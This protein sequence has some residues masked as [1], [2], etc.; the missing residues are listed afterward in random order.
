MIPIAAIYARVS[1][2][3]QEQEATIDSQVDALETYA[4][5][6]GYQTS[7]AL[8]FRDQGI[9]GAQLNRPALNRL[10]D[11]A[12]EGHFQVLLCYSPDRLAR[13]YAHQWVLLDEFRRC[14]IQ[15]IFINQDALPEGPERELWLGFQALFAE[16]ER[17]EITRRLQRGKRY[18]MRQGE[19]VSPRPAYGYQYIPVQEANGGRW[20][21]H[22]QEAAVVRSIYRWYTEEGLTIHQIVHRLNAAG[23]AA[24]P[25]G[26]Q[27]RYST[28]QAILTQPAY[29]GRAYYGRT[30][31][32]Y[33][34]VGRPRRRGRGWRKC[35]EHRPRPPEEWIEIPVPP[36]L[37]EEEWLRAQERLA[38]NRKFAS[39]NN[40]RRFYLLRSLLVC[41]VCGHTMVG[42]GR[43]EKTGYV[44]PYESGNRD[45]DVPPHRCR[46]AGDVVE[47]LVWEAVSH[48][49]RQ[50]T[51][52]AD[53]WR[54]QQEEIK[55]D[56]GE[57]E[58]LQGRLRA[59]QRQRMRLLDAFQDEL[60]EKEELA[61]RKRRLDAE[62]EAIRQRLERLEQEARSRQ[63]K[64]QM[65]EDFAAFCQRIE[66]A[67]RDPTP[68]IQQ[69]VVR[70]L[71][72]HIVVTEDELII[73][74]IIPTDSDCR[75]L[76]GC[77]EVPF[78][79]SQTPLRFACCALLAVT[80]S[81]RA[82]QRVAQ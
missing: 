70:L 8:I 48:L 53:A 26:K 57:A 43:E 69:E 80:T 64:A 41:G 36:L 49:I 56:L 46:I 30:V 32:C 20:I 18:R 63:A 15:V 45:L 71:I 28:V 13:H 10:R 33:E 14:G 40:R 60:I 6:H 11:L 9:S 4:R 21:P 42:R 17:A 2:A 51:L 61:R 72:D 68:E 58:R 82:P 5:Q 35:P 19:L 39:R 54:A 44:C 12:P 37:T 38:M 67:L 50:P 34:A 47:S 27:W 76:P 66:A 31:T 24:P 81:A 1:T 55:E 29:T 73:K 22:P 77:S 16:Y 78:G 79:F 75:L 23:E 52:L 74:H 7:P 65:L 59:L 62:E 3:Q 25:R